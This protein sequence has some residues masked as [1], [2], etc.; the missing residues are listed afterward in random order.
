K[1]LMKLVANK[2][3]VPAKIPQY[4]G[5]E[6]WE[7]LE[8][9]G[10]GGFS[11]VYRARDLDGKAGEVAIKVVPKSGMKQVQHA[12]IAREVQIMRQ[13]DNPN[14]IKFIDFSESRQFYY[15]ILELAPGGE[16]F[17]QILRLKYFSEDLS[18]HII[19]QVA[20]A[21]E[22]LHEEKGIMHRDIKLENILFSPIPFIPSKHQQPPQ[23]NEEDKV[24]E[25]EFIAGIG[26]GCIGQIKIAD[27]GLSKMVQ[28]D[29][30]ATPCGT[31]GYAA[32]EIVKDEP[33]SMSVDIWALG[34]VLYML[35]CGFPP[36]Y[37]ADKNDLTKKVA[38]GQFTFQS[39]WW[40]DIS[41]SAQDLIS[42]SLTVDPD[43]RYTIHEFLSHPWIRVDRSTSTSERGVM[44]G[45]MLRAVDVSNHVGSGEH[46]DLPSLSVIKLHSVFNNSY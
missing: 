8:K 28:N 38:V 3:E 39:P 40:D 32:P 34:C 31:V 23:L 6:R 15:L 4:D 37:G 16:L 36:F 35:L 30:T 21:L 14:I 43:K 33:Y 11:T 42:H 25:G 20:K 17:H 1:D 19:L 26:S 27:F 44:P 2:T 5:L 29:E 45:G 46:C 18:R 9:M 12:N 13:L 24:D 41:R 7:L 10:A 22:Y